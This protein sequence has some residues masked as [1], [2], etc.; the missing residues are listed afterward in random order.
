ML[1]SSMG[2]LSMISKKSNQ[3]ANI[4]INKNAIEVI[5][6]KIPAILFPVGD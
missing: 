4:F 6:Y 1:A 3:N 5:I 2:P